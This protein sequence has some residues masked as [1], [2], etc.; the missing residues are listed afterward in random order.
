MID[1]PVK[2]PTLIN[3]CGQWSIVYPYAYN[4]QEKQV[5]TGKP[6]DKQ[7]VQR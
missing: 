4:R 6:S 5:S 7:D 2:E 3:Q 1:I